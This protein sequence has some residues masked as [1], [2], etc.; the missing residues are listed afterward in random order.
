SASCFAV[1]SHNEMKIFAVTSKG[2]GIAAELSI[3]IE[4]GSGKIWSSISP[5]IGTTTQNTEKLAVKVAKNYFKD[6]DKYDYKFEIRSNASIVEGP[7]AGAAMALLLITMLQDKNLPSH[8]S[9]TGTINAD[10]SIGSVG[11]VLEKTIAAARSGIKLF[12]IPAG[13]AKQTIK[14]GIKIKN[15]DLR[16]YALEKYNIKVVEVRNIDEALRYAFANIEEIDV[17]AAASVLPSFSPSPLKLPSYMLPM[18]KITLAMVEKSSKS[19][20][21][22]KTALQGSLIEDPTIV[23]TLV[24]ALG[25]AEELYAKAKDLADANYLYSAAN[26]AFLATVQAKLV[27]DISTNPSL[28]DPLSVASRDF[29]SEL[30]KKLKS[31]EVDLNVA[32]PVECFDWL[33]A[34]RQRFGYAE[35]NIRIVSESISIDTISTE[36][37]LKQIQDLEFANAWIEAASDMLLNAKLCSGKRLATEKFLKNNARKFL[38]KAEDAFSSYKGE[39]LEDLQRR[40]AAAQTAMA[41]EWYASATF[42]AAIIVATVE[43]TKLRDKPLTELLPI[44]KQ[45]ILVMS[46][47]LESEDKDF[48][49]FAWVRIYYDHAKYFYNAAEFY[50]KEG[51]NG[52]A[53]DMARNSLAIILIAEE[54]FDAAKTTKQLIKEKGINFLVI[55]TLQSQ[56]A[57]PARGIDLNLIVV[58]LLLIVGLLAALV[59]L[60]TTIKKAPIE[61]RVALHSM[62]LEM[63]SSELHTIQRLIKRLQK[64]LERGEISFEDYF[65]TLVIFEK[66]LKELNKRIEEHRK[67]KETP[68]ILLSKPTT[69]KSSRQKR[70]SGRSSKRSQRRS[71]RKKRNR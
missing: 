39:A 11:G 23:N 15:I 4:P 65:S 6:V 61:R 40:M 17:N 9:I 69:L 25:E 33:A 51:F 44:L 30:K 26:Y 10:G 38:I 59:Y 42:D 28:L 29:L 37:R 64:H 22:A 47:K 45:K 67:A 43:A 60:L 58:L 13:E 2:Q 21:E 36:E 54:M 71:K 70:A 55:P 53:L 20:S 62:E 48:N 5:L 66:R 31:L 32:L 57:I 49:G 3:S 34:A 14:E 27:K 46:K 41:R 56:Q 50:K 16:N 68:E 35:F 7:S 63:I 1:I 18:R 52:Q 8:V 19:I 12:M 24:S